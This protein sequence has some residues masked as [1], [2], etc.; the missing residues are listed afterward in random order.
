MPSSSLIRFKLGSASYIKLKFI[1]SKLYGDNE[2]RWY[3]N[4][5]II[6]PNNIIK[7]SALFLTQFTLILNS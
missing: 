5:A 3:Y 7:A 6:Q 4:D 1:I 2:N